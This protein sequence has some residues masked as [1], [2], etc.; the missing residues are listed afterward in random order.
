MEEG[1]G[2][3]GVAFFW[4]GIPMVNF[5]CMMGT[6]GTYFASVLLISF[7]MIWSFLIRFFNEFFYVYVDG[8]PTSCWGNHYASTA[9][10]S[11][12]SKYAFLIYALFRKVES[13]TWLLVMLG[14]MLGVS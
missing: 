6:C 3:L 5:S 8:N 7:M 4:S 14:S 12:W 10:I 9:L 1:K 2:I 11:R 13:L